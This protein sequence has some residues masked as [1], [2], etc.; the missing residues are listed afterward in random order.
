MGTSSISNEY[1][2]AEGTT[3]IKFEEWITIQNPNAHPITAKA[4]YYLASGA[5]ITKEYEIDAARR[6][7]V[8]VPKEEGLGQDVSI[9]LS[10]KHN[11]L[12]ERP[13]YF[14][15]QGMG[16]YGWTGG[17]C[18]IVTSVCAYNWFFAEGCT[19]SGFE[20]WICIQNPG[21][22]EAAVTMTYYPENGSVPI[23]AEHKVAPISRYTILVNADAGP[24]KAISTQVSSDQ[25]I[26]CERHM[27]FNFRGAWDGSHDAVGFP[28]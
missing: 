25:P 22:R 20:P 17:H 14:N 4:T 7:T 13:M 6:Y 11:F 27:Y 24:G 21:D 12:A 8:Y 23:R 10:S 16:A 15:Y 2:F 9:F 26:I 5:P 18:V 19:A 28:Q 3:R 1:Y